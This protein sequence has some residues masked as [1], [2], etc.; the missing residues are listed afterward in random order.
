D[1]DLRAHEPP[2]LVAR[3]ARDADAPTL[4]GSELI[5]P[6]DDDVG[7]DAIR[8]D[9]EAQREPRLLPLVERLLS[10]DRIVRV[11]VGERDAARDPDPQRLALALGPAHEHLALLI[12][13][14]ADV[15]A[16]LVL[17]NLLTH[18]RV[19]ADRRGLL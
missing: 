3:L 16:V 18:N 15:R 5:R 13:N 1:R 17:L 11:P 7:V 14:R 6:R 12:E 19:V 2:A 8:H 9:V 10:D 4:A